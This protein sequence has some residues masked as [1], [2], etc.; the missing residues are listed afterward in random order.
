[1]IMDHFK[2]YMNIN[3]T[4]SHM[5]LY[6][7]DEMLLEFCISLMQIQL[8]ERYI[9]V[10]L[11]INDNLSLCM[12]IHSF[13]VLPLLTDFGFRISVNIDPRNSGPI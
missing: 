5:N 9:L 13:F 12:D 7:N 8:F 1:M 6:R 11:K 4:A 3:Q 10:L 2:T